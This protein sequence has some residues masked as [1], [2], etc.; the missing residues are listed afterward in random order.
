M[1]LRKILSTLVAFA[2]ISAP[3][4]AQAAMSMERNRVSL[5][6]S[7]G[8]A[9]TKVLGLPR[10]YKLSRDMGGLGSS[11]GQPSA[12]QDHGICIDPLGFAAMWVSQDHGICIDPYGYGANLQPREMHRSENV[13]K[14]E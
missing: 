3:L 6:P 5:E 7:Q 1:A 11:R 12:S 13:T 8:L 2:V 10:P 14:V 4:T 9:G